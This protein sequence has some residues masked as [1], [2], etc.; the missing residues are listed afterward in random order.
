MP[1]V[2]VH[3]PSQRVRRFAFERC[4]RPFFAGVRQAMQNGAAAHL[5]QSVVHE[6][7][8][9]FGAWAD[10]E[11]RLGRGFELWRAKFAGFRIA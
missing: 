4:A 7:E 2:S 11:K 3:A 10:S 1:P 8:R 5:L 9:R 6:F